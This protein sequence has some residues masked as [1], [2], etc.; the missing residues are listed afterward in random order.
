MFTREQLEM[1]DALLK[2]E[3]ITTEERARLQRAT[4]SALWSMSKHLTKRERAAIE[5]AERQGK[6]K[7]CGLFESGLDQ[8][9]NI[10][11]TPVKPAQPSRLKPAVSQAK[12]GATLLSELG[13]DF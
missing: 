7:V 10:T 13:L 4:S 5:D 3:E 11:F 9:G 1:I 6:V 2:G 12:D 8:E